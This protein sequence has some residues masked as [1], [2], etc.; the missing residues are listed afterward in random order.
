MKRANN[1][2]VGWARS[3]DLPLPEWVPLPLRRSSLTS[4]PTSRIAAFW[5]TSKPFLGKGP[6]KPVSGNT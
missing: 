2:V 1:E 6:H 3:E 5:K 4:R